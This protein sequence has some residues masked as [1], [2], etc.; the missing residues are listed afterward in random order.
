M[1]QQLTC[2]QLA[3]QIEPQ[4]S[5]MLIEMLVEVYKQYP[6]LSYDAFVFFNWRSNDEKFEYF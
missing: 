2:E 6:R 5:Q 1:P 3:F 4:T